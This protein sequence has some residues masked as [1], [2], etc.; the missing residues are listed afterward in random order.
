MRPTPAVIAMAK[1]PQKVTRRT[2]FTTPAPPTRAP[3]AQTSIAAHGLRLPIE[4]FARPGEARPWGLLSGYRRLMAVRALHEQSGHPR[5][6]T[7]KAVEREPEA[8]IVVDGLSRRV[9]SVVKRGQA[10]ISFDPFEQL[11][12]EP[13]VTITNSALAL[14][15]IR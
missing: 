15:G 5:F 2:D 14:F 11:V 8:N 10:G 7:I 9:A 3:M 4:V 6:A 13:A 12:W 1:A